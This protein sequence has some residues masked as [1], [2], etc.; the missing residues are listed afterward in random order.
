MAEKYP[1]KYSSGK[2]VSAA[3]Y[4]TE[5]ICER[6]AA[7]DKKDLHHRFWLNKEW[8]R[9]FRDQIASAH[10]L[11]N[12]YGD[13]AVVRALNNKKAERIY[14]LRAPH[15]PGIIEYERKLLE[16]ENTKLSQT[17][18][19]EEKKTYRKP[20]IKNSISKLKDIDNES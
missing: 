13:R 19:R 5:L 3:Q 8:S 11:I 16:S 15:L 1:S 10:K 17:Y 6:K 4:I 18:N 14:S 9:F 12:K 20:V 2:Q 7:M